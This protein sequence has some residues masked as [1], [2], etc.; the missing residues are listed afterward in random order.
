MMVEAIATSTENADASTKEASK[1]A[2]DG[3]DV[4]ACSFFLRYSDRLGMAYGAA[5]C[6]DLRTFGDD[7]DVRLWGSHWVWGLRNPVHR[8]RRIGRLWK[9]KLRLHAVLHRWHIE[10]LLL[11]IYR[12]R[13]IR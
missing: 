5:T 12:R 1:A 13:S 10:L 7:H 4:G 9:C 3:P 8:L 11:F 2:H 6:R